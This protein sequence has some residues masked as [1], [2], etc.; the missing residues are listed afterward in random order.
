MRNSSTDSRH[1]GIGRATAVTLSVNGWR[2]VLSGRRLSALQETAKLCSGP[3][4]LVCAGDVSNEED[5]GKLFAATNAEFG[6]T[7]H[8]LLAPPLFIHCIR[9]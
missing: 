1:L 9:F 6:E 4:A 2:V 5:V 8:D 7:C 3:P